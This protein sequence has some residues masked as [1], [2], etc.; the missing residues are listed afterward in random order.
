MLIHA[1]YNGVSLSFGLLYPYMFVFFP[2]LS[3][4]CFRDHPEATQQMNDLIIAKV[5]AALKGHWANPDLV[6]LRGHTENNLNPTNIVF[7]GGG[8]SRVAVTMNFTIK[9]S[10]FKIHTLFFVFP[11][12]G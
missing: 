3:I 1:V 2:C 9:S 8:F 12:S 7:V 10:D 4:F 11:P 6:G 5:S